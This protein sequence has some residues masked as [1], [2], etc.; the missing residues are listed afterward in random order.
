MTIEATVSS[1]DPS[2]KFRHTEQSNVDI[3]WAFNLDTNQKKK[4]TYYSLSLLTN[5]C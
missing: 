1:I 4:V 5:L 2:V 3:V